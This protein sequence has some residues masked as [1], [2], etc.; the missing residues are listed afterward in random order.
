MMTTILNRKSLL[1]WVALFYIGYN[2]FGQSGSGA[3]VYCKDGSIYKGEIT[4]ES[5]QTLSLVIFTLDTLELQ[6]FMIRRIKRAEDNLLLPDGRTHP[7]KG[8]FFSAKLGLNLGSAFSAEDLP[9]VHMELM[10]GHRL[11]R[12]WTVAGG[13]GAENNSI[14]VGG[15]VVETEF[16]S[17][18]GYGRYYITN[19]RRR[20]F[21]YGRVGY[22]FGEKEDNTDRI[23]QS[24]GWNG[25][26]GAGF[27]FPSRRSTTFVISLGY[28]VQMTNGTEIF[29]DSMG[30]EV[31]VDYDVFIQ[32]P[33][34]KV[35]VEF[36]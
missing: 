17:F 36:W 24:G 1:I 10:M 3:I 28:Y 2:G 25:Q 33:L 35:G 31:L 27:H 5:D 6:K 32:R 15:F 30:S 4:A 34:L 12:R 26:I 8:L 23:T 11:N 20:L 29:L 9:S 7:T 21:T 16:V 14:D 19:S 22:G 18:F 13:L